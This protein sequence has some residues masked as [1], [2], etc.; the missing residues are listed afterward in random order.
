MDHVHLHHV[1]PPPDDTE[2][3][4]RPS[5]ERVNEMLRRW[6]ELTSPWGRH[7]LGNV[8]ALRLVTVTGR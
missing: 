5:P 8:E 7:Q 6:Y 4:I 3:L 1:C 2:P